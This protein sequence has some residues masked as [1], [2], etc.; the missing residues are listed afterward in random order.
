M[1]RR[2]QLAHPPVRRGAPGKPL[3]EA[4]PGRA[5]HPRAVPHARRHAPPVPRRGAGPAAVRPGAQGGAHSLPRGRHGEHRGGVRQQQGLRRHVRQAVQARPPPPPLRGPRRPHPEHR[6]RQRRRGLLYHGGVP[7]R[8][9]HQ[10]D[11][12]Q[13]SDHRGG[14]GHAQV[15]RRARRG[16]GGGG[17]HRHV[18]RRRA[19]R[20][21]RELAARRRRRRSL[22]GRGAH[23]HRP[24]RAVRSHCW[25]GWHAQRRRR[26]RGG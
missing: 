5:G 17:H 10:R 1:A 22:R 25:C 7:R 19:P 8:G 14:R 26:G 15:A 9:P 16:G 12:A 23:S 18:A 3:G 6:G 21:H 11:G 4:D 20:R 13:R 2:A 24:P